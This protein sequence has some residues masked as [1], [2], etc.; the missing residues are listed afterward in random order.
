MA[1]KSKTLG[2][3]RTRKGGGL[4]RRPR[5][6]PPHTED[7]PVPLATTIPRSIDRALRQLAADTDRPMSEHLAHALRTY[8]RRQKN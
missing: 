4:T 7:P 8:I 3:T 5:G 2:S 6:R 1:K